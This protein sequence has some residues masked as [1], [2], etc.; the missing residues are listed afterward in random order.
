MDQ[1]D[2]YRSMGRRLDKRRSIRYACTVRAFCNGRITACAP[3][4]GLLKILFLEHH[5]TTRQ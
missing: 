4:F 3:H 5:A 2:C 1:T